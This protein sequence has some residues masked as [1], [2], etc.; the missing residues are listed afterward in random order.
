MRGKA[1][2]IA[3]LTG[4]S[5]QVL[6]LLVYDDLGGP[7]GPAHHVD[8]SAGDTISFIDNKTDQFL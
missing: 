1:D 4:G 6:L 7:P 8:A 5:P 3:V 2:F